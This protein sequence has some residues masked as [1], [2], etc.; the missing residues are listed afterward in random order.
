MEST[1]ERE[2]RDRGR[3]LHRGPPL[4]LVAAI[5][6][7]LVILGMVICTA[8]AGAAFPS[9][10]TPRAASDAYFLAHPAAVRVLAFFEAGAAIPLA[11]FTATVASRLLFLGMRVAGVHIALAGGLVASALEGAAACALWTISQPGVSEIPAVTRPLHLLAFA[12]VGPAAIG[13]FGLLV[14]GASVVAGLPGL[15]PRWLM[16]AGLAIAAAAELSVLTFLAPLFA[17]L[18]PLARFAGFAWMICLGALLPTRRSESSGLR[19]PPVAGR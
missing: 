18:L 2:P 11:V 3:P 12:A 6:A 5:H 4:A 15:V 1:I 19:P 7:A 8:M 17:W 10:F 9:P 16:L 14:A 13:S